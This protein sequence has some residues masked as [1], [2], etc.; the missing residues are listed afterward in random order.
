MH[1]HKCL[2]CGLSIECINNCNNQNIYLCKDCKRHFGDNYIPE[3]IPE[4]F[5]EQCIGFSCIVIFDI[6]C[7]ICVNA[8]DKFESEVDTFDGKTFTEEDIKEVRNTAI[9]AFFN[10]G[11]TAYFDKVTKEIYSACK[12]CAKE[13]QLPRSRKYKI[14]ESTKPN[15]V[16]NNQEIIKNNILEIFDLYYSDKISANEVVTKIFSIDAK[17]SA[18]L[19][20]TMIK[21]YGSKKNVVD[22]F[23]KEHHDNIIKFLKFSDFSKK[24]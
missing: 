10:K 17:K 19:L 20:Y 11:W 16:S 1:F 23:I 21:T 6:Y 7:A 15:T 9:E 2:E 8:E 22:Y 4:V 5:L 3:L 14:S 12:K 18:G 24:E 13:R